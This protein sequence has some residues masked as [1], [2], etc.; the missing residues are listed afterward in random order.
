M[1]KK[2]T[3]RD[4]AKIAGVSV[5][6]VSNVIN[7]ID[8]VS[9]ETKRHVLSVMKGLDYQPNL[10]AR[11]LARNKSNLIGL[12]L[13]ITDEGLDASLLLRDNPF[14]GEFISGAE[15]VADEKGYD[16]L[17][18]GV[19][20]GQSC[21]EWIAK[22]NLDGA[23][24]IGNY[25]IVIA[26]DVKKCN[27]QLVLIDTYD[28]GIQNFHNIGIDDKLGGYIGTRYLLDMGH[29][30]IAFAGSNILV[31]GVVHRRFEGYKQA[32]GEEQ[33]DR[34]NS[35][36]FQEAISFEGG[37]RIGLKILERN[38][39][40]TAVFTAADI[41]AFGIMK[42]FYEHGKMIP[43]DLSIVGFDDISTCKYTFPS[44]TSVRQPIYQKGVIAAE[45]LIDAVENGVTEIKNIKVPIELVERDSVRKISD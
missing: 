28:E 32:M 10:T 8:K 35:L 13:P 42:A 27:S 41:M 44:L 15:F 31:D 30:Q 18:T 4:V 43:K 5:A 9:E 26:E 34:F 2:A 6:T 20:P 22:R 1:R 12:L 3:V 39:Q 16:I 11:S 45:T 17:I 36:I 38:Q 29:R 24:F 25:S 14:Y 37:Y 19:R 7:G 21:R 40:I 33:I 23:V